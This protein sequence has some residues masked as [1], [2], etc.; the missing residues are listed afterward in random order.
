MN[1]S[2]S[3]APS[4][5]SD[6]LHIALFLASLEGN[7]KDI[8]HLIAQGADPLKPYQPSSMSPLQAATIKLRLEAVK[9][10]LPH[11]DPNY[12]DNR[13]MT[14]L[15]YA[16]QNTP[17]NHPPAIFFTL[18]PL[19][20]TSLIDNNGMSLL[21][22][23]ADGGNPQIILSAL[24]LCDPDA[25]NARGATPLHIASRRQNP[26]PLPLA[27]PS[28]IFLKDING[29]TPIDIYNS[30]LCTQQAN[31]L[32]SFAS[33]HSEQNTLRETL[34]ANLPKNPQPKL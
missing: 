15:M 34:R 32:L 26:N 5:N 19:T 9:I 14:A 30:C 4:P 25:T 16:A 6:P 7:T 18:L 10:L 3:H 13:G 8:Q 21:H 31:D 17:A 24:P 12:Q 28:N 2:H 20:N 22:Y 27:T 1:H 29:V 33:S 23:A 11:S